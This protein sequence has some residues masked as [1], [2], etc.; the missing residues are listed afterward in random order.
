MPKRRIP[1][2]AKQLAASRR[3]LVIARRAKRSK[4]KGKPEG[5]AAFT[6]RKNREAMRSLR[7]S[8][9]YTMPDGSKRRATKNFR[10]VTIIHNDVKPRVRKR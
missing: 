3:N 4:R 9:T 5:K 7:W 8:T 6:H 10:G 2:T 1:R